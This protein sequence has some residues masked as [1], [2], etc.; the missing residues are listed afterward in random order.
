MLVTGATGCATILTGTHQDLGLAVEPA[1]AE[2]SVYHMNG[3]RM[4]G[5][6]ASPGT[7]KVH[8][9]ANTEAYLVVASRSGYCPKYWVTDVRENPVAWGNL[10]LGGIVGLLVDA[11]NGAA[12]YVEPGTISATLVDEGNCP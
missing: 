4:A 1:G 9:P 8:R 3:E 5:P 2:V 6:A 10:L 7:V 12:Y 11:S